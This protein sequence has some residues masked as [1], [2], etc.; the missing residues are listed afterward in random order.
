MFYFKIVITAAAQ[1]LSWNLFFV[2]QSVP[3]N[4]R[5]L[6]HR[7]PIILTCKH[8]DVSDAKSAKYYACKTRASPSCH[9]TGAGAG[10]ATGAAAAAGRASAGAGHAGLRGLEFLG[11]LGCL[12]FLACRIRGRDVGRC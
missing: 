11:C 6:K 8:V 9:V 12:C 5:V 1:I 3:A 10:A 4:I 7:S 2:L